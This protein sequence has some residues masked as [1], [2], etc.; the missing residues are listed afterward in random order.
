MGYQK[1]IVRK[2]KQNKTFI[3]TKYLSVLHTL[4]IPYILYWYI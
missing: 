3:Y 1:E 2:T 4:Y